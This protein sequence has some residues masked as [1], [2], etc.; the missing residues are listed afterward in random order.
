MQQWYSVSYFSMLTSLRH[1]L[2][3]KLIISSCSPC[4]VS[5]DLAGSERIKVSGVTGSALR[6]ATS[7][8]SSLSALG[9]V[10]QALDQKNKHVPYR[11]SKL[12]FLLQVTYTLQ[13]PLAR[14]LADLWGDISHPTLCAVH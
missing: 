2:S 11:N 14:G 7:I 12:T 8:N 10:M 6:E 4:A 13:V 3:S 9:D 5:V 1:T